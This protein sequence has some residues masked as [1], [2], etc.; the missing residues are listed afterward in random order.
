MKKLIAMTAITSLLLPS[1]VAFAS[2]ED[3]YTSDDASYNKQ[4]KEVKELIEQ[5]KTTTNDDTMQTVID[6]V[7]GLPIATNSE[8][9]S[10]EALFGDVFTVLTGIKDK[11]EQEKHLVYFIDSAVYQTEKSL[12]KADLELAYALV[13]QLP[14]GTFKDNYMTKLQK[15]SD[16]IGERILEDLKENDLAVPQFGF[17]WS[18][19]PADSFDDYVPSNNNNDYRPGYPLPTRPPVKRNPDAVKPDKDGIADKNLATNEPTTDSYTNYK[20]FTNT[21]TGNRIDNA[22]MSYADLGNDINT[23]DADSLTLQYTLDKHAEDPYFYETN[24][25]VKDGMMT[26]QQQKDVLSQMAIRSGGRTVDDSDSFLVLLE[27]KIIVIHEQDVLIPVD[28]FDT[29]LEDFDAQVK[30]LKPQS[31]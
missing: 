9:T 27:N 29:L 4:V 10:K 5:A 22:T 6:K 31:Y 1:T 2:I 7:V 15:I 14:D 19:L 21:Q 25:E 17:D 12:I 28:V 20:N 26:Y 13:H 23:V 30:A 16:D 24:M 18:D 11:K 8:L 3:Y